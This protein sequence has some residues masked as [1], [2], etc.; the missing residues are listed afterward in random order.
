M[1]STETQ[2]TE[3]G[4]DSN[5]AIGADPSTREFRVLFCSWSEL[6]IASG[7]PVIVCDLLENF[8]PGSA[9]AITQLNPDNQH[10]RQINLK[11][12]VRKIKFHT[13]LWPFRRGHRIR[14]RIVQWGAPLLALELLRRVR[15]FRPDC[16]IAVY[17]QPHWI[18]ATWLVS[19]WTGLP[20]I[21]HVHDTFLE[22]TEKRRRSRF[23]AWLD[24]RGADVIARVGA[25]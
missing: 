15:A 6:D 4:A 7:T 18:L 25:A 5:L 13:R 8:S 10:R 20:L 3:A 12:P 14:N 21:Y 1:S 9:E 24:R 11:H 17:A 16:I 19:R 23:A 2:S 22:Q